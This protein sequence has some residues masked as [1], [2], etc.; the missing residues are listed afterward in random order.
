MSAGMLP[1]VTL[2]ERFEL[3]TKNHLYFLLLVL[4][5]GGIR[6][7]HNSAITWKV[8]AI[9]G[10]KHAELHDTLKHGLFVEI[11]SAKIWDEPVAD[12]EKLMEADNQDQVS[13]LTDHEMHVVS[14]IHKAMSSVAGSP[15]KSMWDKVWQILQGSNLAL[16][17]SNSTLSSSIAL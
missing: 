17:P 6:C 4:E 5:H 2:T 11:L 14:K 12:I 10:N 3:A 1:N 13:G 16:Q 9:D 15:T 7:D 8:P